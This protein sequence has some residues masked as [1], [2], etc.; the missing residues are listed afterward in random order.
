MGRANR[1]RDALGDGYA[2]RNAREKGMVRTVLTDGLG[3]LLPICTEVLKLCTHIA[4][5][6]TRAMAVEFSG[7]PRAEMRW[8]QGGF[9]SDIF[10][11]LGAKLVGWPRGVPFVNLSDTSITTRH[12]RALLH[13]WAAGDMQWRA[14]TLGER[15]AAAEHPRNACPGPRFQDAIPRGGRNDVGKRRA[16]RRPTANLVKYPPRF[17]RDGPKSGRRVDTDDEDE[18]EGEGGSAVPE[19]A[20]ELEGLE[21]IEDVGDW[22]LPRRRVVRGELP[23]DPIDS[24][25]DDD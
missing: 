22:E 5:E 3:K 16:P 23:E 17:V 20:S 12:I 1:L 14:N 19:G 13:A 15:L 10:L 24:F 8:T 11:G 9:C 4:D 18:G 2:N 25:S 7:Y 21:E 6:L